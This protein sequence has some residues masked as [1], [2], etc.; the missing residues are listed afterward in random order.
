KNDP[1]YTEDQP[2]SK[3]AA[4][5]LGYDDH[6]KHRSWHYI[7]RPLSPDGTPLV[8]PETPNVATQIRALRAALAADD[9]SDDVKSYALVWLLHLVGAVPQP[10]HCV[11]RFD[12]AQ[13][14]GDSGG[15]AVEITGGS[16]PSP[17]DDPRYCPYGPPKNLHFFW[18]DL[19]GA[20][21][22]TQPALAA[23]ARLPKPDPKKAAVRDEEVWID[24]GFELARTVVYVPP[25]GV[26][27]GPFT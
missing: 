14:R 22:A 21:Y 17:C 27:A 2:R 11:A 1:A 19:E 4:Q 8:P 16:Q 24:E 5:S 9:T 18:D 6:F 3:V 15:N 23:S 20:S 13:P 10:L 26:G 25:I 12:R 7:N